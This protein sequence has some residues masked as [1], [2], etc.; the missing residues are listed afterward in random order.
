MFRAA[1]LH[2]ENRD[3]GCNHGQFTDRFR[4]SVKGT[5]GLPNLGETTAHEPDKKQP[6][7]SNDTEL[8]L[9]AFGISHLPEKETSTGYPA[10]PAVG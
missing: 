5:D 8:R 1:I 4:P 7:S 2:P 3:E 9:M 10:A 6:V